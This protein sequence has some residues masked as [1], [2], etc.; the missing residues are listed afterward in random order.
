MSWTIPTTR[1]DGTALTDIAGFN[2]YYGTSSGTYPNTIALA[3]PA[4][5]TYVVTNLPT[6]ATYYFVMTA[7]DA[8]GV[9]SAYTNA[10]SKSM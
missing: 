2:I 7:Y 6:G 4:L 1:T 10:G 8:N 3:N 5:T 9:E